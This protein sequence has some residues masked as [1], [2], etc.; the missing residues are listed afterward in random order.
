MNEF[1][2]RNESID[3]FFIESEL[4][5]DAVEVRRDGVHVE[6]HTHIIGQLGDEMYMG[7]I[8]YSSERPRN[9]ESGHGNRAGKMYGFSKW[10]AKWE[11]AGPEADPNL[12]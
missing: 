6:G 8:G 11:P 4:H 9:A 7:E 3:G 2:P 5:V 10:G 1:E 12:N